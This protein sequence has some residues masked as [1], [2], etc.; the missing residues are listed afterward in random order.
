M[1]KK[2]RNYLEEAHEFIEQNSRE[3]AFMDDNSRQ[4]MRSQ[5]GPDQKTKVRFIHLN[6]VLSFT[7]TDGGVSDTSFVDISIG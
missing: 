6:I 1:T 4:G 2:L 3:H 5:S 7:R